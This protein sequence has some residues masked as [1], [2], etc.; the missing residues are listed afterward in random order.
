M[1]CSSHLKS[2]KHLGIQYSDVEQTS[3]ADEESGFHISCYLRFN[4]LSQA[5]RAKIKEHHQRR[6]R[7][8]WEQVWNKINI[9][10]YNQSF[11]LPKDHQFLAKIYDFCLSTKEDGYHNIHSVEFKN[12]AKVIPLAKDELSLGKT[13]KAGCI[14]EQAS[15]W[16]QIRNAHKKAFL[17]LADH[18]EEVINRK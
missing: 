11:F 7:F 6:N 5:T 1:R 8:M 15:L 14:K 18:I 17:V 13:D 12:T 16:Y 10:C 9:T 3:S 4:A 2:R